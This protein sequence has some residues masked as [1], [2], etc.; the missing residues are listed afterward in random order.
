MHSLRHAHLSCLGRPQIRYAGYLGRVAAILKPLSGVARYAA[1][2][3]DVGEAF[4]PVV[5]PKLVK[6][7]YAVAWTYVAGDIAYHTHEA[8][9]A[10]RDPVRAAAHA[11]VFQVTASMLLPTLIIHSQVHLASKLARHFNRFVRF[12][13]TVAG[14]ALIP[15]L[16]FICD[17]PVEHLVNEAF[18]RY[19]PEPAAKEH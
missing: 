19:W 15:A 4:R 6:A 10:G 5:S 18:A 7:S 9:T 17:E 11:T 13:P 3:S 14:L 16:P 12:G 2:T 1:F 8:R